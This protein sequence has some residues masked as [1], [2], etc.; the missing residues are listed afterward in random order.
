MRISSIQML[1]KFFEK[2]ICVAN[3]KA[4][5]T[6]QNDI[7]KILFLHNA[8]KIQNC[9]DF[10][11]QKINPCSNSVEQASTTLSILYAY[12]RIIFII[13]NFVSTC[14]LIILIKYSMT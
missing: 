10:A 4:S 14:F 6:A 12:P 3:I 7:N 9:L 1:P 2:I 13:Y 5:I 8:N 11:L